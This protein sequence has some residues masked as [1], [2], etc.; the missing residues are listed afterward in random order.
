MTYLYTKYGDVY[1]GYEWYEMIDYPE[2]R[3]LIQY[4]KMKEYEKLIKPEKKLEKIEEYGWVLGH[5]VIADEI[6]GNMFR[7]PY[8]HDNEREWWQSSFERKY[9]FVFGAGASAN[10][11]SG[12]DKQDFEK[13]NLRPPLGISLFEKRFKKY[14]EKYEG[15]KDSLSFLQGQNLD[16]EAFLEEEWKSISKHNNETVLSRHINIQYYLQDVLKDVSNHATETYHANLYAKFFNKLQKI[17]KSSV[18]NTGDGEISAKNFSFISFNQDTIL[19]HFAC[20]QFK[21][22]IKSM[23]D[24]VSINEGIFSLFKPHG[25]WNWGWKFPDTSNFSDN[26]A[27]WLFDNNV[28]YYDLYYKLLGDPISMVDWNRYGSDIALNAHRLGKFTID[29]SKLHIIKTEPLN[30]YF[31]ALLIPYRDKDEFTMPLRHFRIMEQYLTYTET[32]VLIGWKGNEAAFN[33]LLLLKA[34]RLNKI[35]IVDPNPDAVRQNLAEVL[36]KYKIEPV[37]YKTFE[38]FVESGVEK[39]I[40]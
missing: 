22:D 33:R 28:N 20:K 9:M 8:S 5:D 16:V 36:A 15:V 7:P 35:I 17:Y 27:K 38:E 30:N 40:V 4:D 18:K 34:S 2:Y 37:V 19:E 6:D 13:D 39:E 14:Y 12:D 24:Y 31:P 3:I 10:C 21:K 29:K 1:S 23:D 11:V 25:S 26:T 32:L